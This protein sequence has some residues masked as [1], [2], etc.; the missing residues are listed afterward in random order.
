M[1]SRKKANLIMFLII[2]II[3][4]SLSSIASSFTPELDLDSLGYMNN[5]D[6]LVKVDDGN[7][8]YSSVSYVQEKKENNTTVL[9]NITNYTEDLGNDIISNVSQSY[10]NWSYRDG[11]QKEIY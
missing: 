7:F 2:G 1:R 11:Y 10:Q 3:G 5:T 8:N 4:F 9:D 6:K